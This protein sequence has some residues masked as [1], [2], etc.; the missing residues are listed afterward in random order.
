VFVGR[1]VGR[2]QLISKPLCGRDL[3]LT[4]DDRARRAKDRNLMVFKLC[5]PELPGGACWPRDARAVPRGCFPGPELGPTRGGR[6][7]HNERLQQAGARRACA[8]ATANAVATA[9][10]VMSALGRRVARS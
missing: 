7:P 9:K 3:E 8:R 6:P 1:P 2:P 10:E 5:F 4:N